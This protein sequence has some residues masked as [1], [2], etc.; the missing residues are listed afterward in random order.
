MKT[1]AFVVLSLLLLAQLETIP[2]A[3]AQLIVIAESIP[4]PQGPDL[5]GYSV[6]IPISKIK[7]VK[8]HWSEYIEQDSYGWRSGKNGIHR[9]K[10]MMESSISSEKFTIYSEVVTT[11]SGVRLT[12]WFE[13][14]DKALV[15][16]ESGDK[17]DLAIKKYIHDFAIKQYRDAIQIQLKEKQLHKRRKEME[18][19]GLS[20]AQKNSST[21]QTHATFKEQEKTILSSIEYQN[22]KMQELLDLMSSIR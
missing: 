5:A 15:A 20:N 7:K 11:D 22:V 19:A 21:A 17:L 6:I 9:Q 3:L 13:Q 18:L 2:S 4:D 8:N 12:V 10:G 14:N 1:P 16:S